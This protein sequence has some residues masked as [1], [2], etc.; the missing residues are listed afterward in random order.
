MAESI[1]LRPRDSITP[2]GR[3][4]GIEDSKIAQ[5]FRPAPENSENVSRWTLSMRNCGTR[6]GFWASPAAPKA[7]NSKPDAYVIHCNVVEVS[8]V[9]NKQSNPPGSPVAGNDR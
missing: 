3:Q 7:R 6:F 2:N 5:G 8:K 9:S 1:S 4:M